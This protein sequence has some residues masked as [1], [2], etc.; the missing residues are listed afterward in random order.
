M[1][2]ALQ[3]I[4]RGQDAVPRSI[5]APVDGW[6]SEDP[7][8]AMRPTYAPVLDNWIPRGGKIEMRRGFIEQC[9][10]TAD[11]VE[12]LL[13][14]SAG[15]GDTLFACAGS[16]IYD[17]TSAGGLPAASYSSAASARWSWINFANDAGRFILMCNGAQTPMKYNGSAFS[18]NAITG[19]SG[20]I[21][22]VDDDLKYVFIH[23]RRVHW[24]EKE[25]L[26]VWFLPVTSI[27]G[28]SDLLDLGPIFS[29]GGRFVGGDT[30]SRD[31][32]AGGMDDLAVYV[33]SEGQAAIYQGTDPG[34]V[35]A[36]VLVG[37]FEFAKPVGD[38]PIYRDGGELYII[39][40]EGL[41]PLSGMVGAQRESQKSLMRSRKIASKWADAV[42]SYKDQLGWESVYYPGRGG[43]TIVNAPTEENVSAVQFVQNAERGAWCRFTGI[44]AGCWGIANGMGY[45][46]AAAGVYRWDVGASDNSEPI[47]PDVLPAFQDFG[48]RAVLKEFTMVRPL[49]YAPSIVQPA[50]DI[51]T[52]YDLATLPTAVATTVSPDDIDPDDDKTI[53]DAWTGAAGVGYVAAPRLRF[54]LTGSNDVDRVSVTEDLT[55]LLLEGPGGSDHILT[56]PNLPLDVS[57]EIV[58]FDLMFKIG[59]QL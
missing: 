27:A 15:G 5:P 7:L 22:L 31:N 2:T 54:S 40:E 42:S 52:D 24:L 36:W 3:P 13:T 33:T 34:D 25:N 12:T 6:N 38:R 32:G 50:I 11:P 1:R 18:T 37:V 8:A 59:G 46:G 49:Y 20:S 41:A 57:V 16:Y 55:S 53:R 23:Q 43:L 19:T 47:V 17:V 29:K 10:G 45:F 28:A 39:T 4:R 44:N 26:R 51:V 21:T 9:T 58:G 48:S 35:D 14:Y 56:R 30:W